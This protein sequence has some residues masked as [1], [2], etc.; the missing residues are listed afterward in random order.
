MLGLDT[1]VKARGIEILFQRQNNLVL[2]FHFFLLPVSLVVNGQTHNRKRKYQQLSSCKKFLR[3]KEKKNRA[4][5]LSESIIEKALRQGSWP[6][7]GQ[8]FPILAFFIIK[9]P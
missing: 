7:L 4:D 9:L 6:F 1:D 2:E 8:T 3:K 5:L